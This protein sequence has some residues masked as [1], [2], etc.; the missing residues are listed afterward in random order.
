MQ[1]WIGV[2]KGLS[3]LQQ[4]VIMWIEGWD[5]ERGASN[6]TNGWDDAILRRVCEVVV[7]MGVRSGVNE[8]WLCVVEFERSNQG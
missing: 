7:G 4:D 2:A 6:G 1:E 3:P 5:L 8:Q